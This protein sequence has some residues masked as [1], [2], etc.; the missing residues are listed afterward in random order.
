MLL[1]IRAFLRDTQRWHLYRASVS[2][3]TGYC[4]PA[5][6]PTMFSPLRCSSEATTQHP[7]RVI[8][9]SDDAYIMHHYAAAALIPERLRWNIARAGNCLPLDDSSYYSPSLLGVWSVFGIV[10]I[11]LYYNNAV[12]QKLQRIDLY[13]AAYGRDNA[14][15]QPLDAPR[16]IRRHW[17]AQPAPAEYAP[18]P[19]TQYRGRVRLI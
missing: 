7:L 10:E 17:Q 15:R 4:S 11:V 19:Y 5:F 16:Y 18:P 14:T 9:W 8:R 12:Q 3:V 13:R 2:F 1:M 6:V